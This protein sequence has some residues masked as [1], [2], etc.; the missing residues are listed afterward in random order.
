MKGIVNGVMTWGSLVRRA[1]LVSRWRGPIDPPIN[2]VIEDSR[3]ARPGA[4]FVAVRG[5]K[6]DG[7][8]YVEAAVKAGAAAVVCE[9]PIAM[10][11]SVAV[12]EVASA[13]G[14][15]SRLA[16]AL[17]GLDETLREGRLKLV[18]ITGT[19]GKS[20]FCYLV[21][22]I[23]RQAGL[24]T[25]M[26]GTVQ[27]DLL[28][29]SVEASMTTP[30]AT[31]LA[32]YL[33][34][35]ANA[36]ASH[37]VMEVSSHALDQGRCDGLRF[38]VGVFSNLTGDHLD[39]HKTMD[40]YL[41]AKKRL[42]DR[43]APDAV[44]A[45]NAEDPAAERMVTDCR[46]RV[47]RYG[48]IADLSKGGPGGVGGTAAPEGVARVEDLDVFARVLDGDARGTRF[49][50][51][52]RRGGSLRSGQVES[53]QVN[54]VLV[55]RH[56]VQ[57]CLAAV[58]A[59][60]GLGLPLGRIV[61]GLESVR[62]VPGRLQRVEGNG[63][64]VAVLVDYAHTDDALMN[65]LRA[66]RPIAKRRLIVLF[67]CGGDR[68]RSKRP[69]MAKAVA[70]FA[71]CILVTSDNPRSEEPRGIIDDILPGFAPQDMERVVVEPDRRKAIA[72]AIEMASPGDV[73]L[74]AGKG[75]ETY[76]E[77]R[78]QRHDFDDVAIAA[79]ILKGKSRAS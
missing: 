34:E 63:S 29:R 40:E 67:G 17:W 55:G 43:L 25:A 21:R 72:A 35:A 46:A 77:I 22:S 47:L 61:A 45:V 7:H 73:V 41:R 79:E 38:A 54:S 32:G 50:V 51:T 42:F 37:A 65:V 15:A 11:P 52:V 20:T 44:G 48:I 56:N 3:Q 39:Y 70:Q 78:G 71:D 2:S 10:P 14:L 33:A 4:C 76:Q 24:P 18:G 74:L 23:L 26:L 36:G 69:R 19:N 53:Q 5:T 49:E 59:A 31:V 13:R 75:H 1:G 6:A 60:V 27:Y 8:D 30:P 58:S 66:V 57:N 28:S 62:I 16:V 9:R 68:D 64:G 12:L